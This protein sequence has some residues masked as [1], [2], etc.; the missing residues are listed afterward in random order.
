[1]EKAEKSGSA[2][3]G[4]VFPAC[5]H[6]DVC[7]GC[8]WQGTAYGEQLSA[9][10][11]EVLR[12]LAANDVRAGEYRPARAT[13]GIHGYRNKMEYSFGDEVKDGP[14]T[15]GL[16]RRKSYMAVINTDGCRIVPEAFNVLR[17]AVLDWA[18]RA[19]HELYHKRSHTGFLRSLVLRRGERTGELLVNLVTTDTETLDE[20]AFVEMILGLQL[21]GTQ[22][23]GSS[24]L[25][26]GNTDEPSPCVVGILHTINNRR[27]DVI[28]R[29]S[30][31]VLYGR[32]H[33]FEEMLGLRFRVDAFAFFQTNTSAVEDMLTEAFRMLPEG[34][35]PGTLYDI[36]CG[37]GTISLAL[38]DRADR[39]VGIEIVP[40]SV[41]AA[42]ENAALNGIENCDFICGDALAVLDETDAA[43]RRP[44]MIVVD[45][46]RMGMH[47]KAL[48]KIITY[49]LPRI[50]YI[51]CN[52]KTF[53]EN[54]AA[55]QAAGY[56]LDTLGVY[57]NFPFTK[58]TELV[59]MI[60]KK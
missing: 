26:P 1:M 40:D 20:A 33:Y 44:D 5:P 8:T 22:G 4:V 13:S 57:D 43:G 29:D 10:N 17:A 6:A 7:G 30:L 18:E 45:P 46:P 60:V 27:S 51:S 49:G 12:L 2:E 37:T 24:V 32:G 11:A 21:A 14:T 39:V 34:G 9:K 41:T 50:L 31:K 3:G 52:P 55:L 25:L 48:K 28:A 36:Y 47:P 58:H 23:D 15:L 38:A 54:M 35:L 16:H 53:C 42:R 59:G 56:K 19:G